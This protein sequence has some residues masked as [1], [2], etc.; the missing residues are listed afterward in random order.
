MYCPECGAEYRAGFF[1][2][3]DCDVPLVHEL[4]A[5]APRD[6]EAPA[7]EVVVF[8]SAVP[9]ET[10]MVAGALEEAGITGSIRRGI[11]GGLR[12]GML[13]GGLT[14]GQSMIL[15]VP[16][17]AASRARELISEIRPA[18]IADTSDTRD[19]LFSPAEPPP[20]LGLRPRAKAL[21]RIVLLLVLVPMGLA[22]LGMIAMLVRAL[23]E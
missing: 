21:T 7:D 4:P 15:S 5:D 6:R 2:C 12:M 23:F 17:L 1:Q 18:E 19:D 11:A 8:E 14:P 22:A 16:G 10:E 3:S 9:G 13:D 20:P